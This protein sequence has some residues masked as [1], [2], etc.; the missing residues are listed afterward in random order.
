[1]T[2]HLNHCL[3]KMLEIAE[4]GSAMDLTTRDI[5]QF[6]YNVGR[7]AELSGEG[8]ENWWDLFKASVAEEDW[9]TV[10]EIVLEKMR[11]QGSN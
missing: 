4:M 5:F 2:E 7:A 8:R 10:Y 11:E 1:M 3:T 6:G 9:S